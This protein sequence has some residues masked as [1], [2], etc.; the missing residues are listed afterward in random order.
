MTSL[1]I[2]DRPTSRRHGRMRTYAMHAYRMGLLAVIVGLVHAEHRWFTAQK[3][4]Q[5]SESVAID[6]VLPLF[7]N[8]ASLGP[9]NPDHG[10]Q[11]VLNSAG[12]SLGFV[13]QTSP[14]SDDVI[15]FSG[16]I[17]TLVAFGTDN[18]IC[19]MTV[20]RSGDTREHTEDV[21]HNESFMKSLHGLNWQQASAA[22]VDS[23]SGATLT[24]MS[25][26]DG[27]RRRLGG[28]NPSSR[29][30][31]PITI[32]EASAFFSAATGLEPDPQKPS[33]WNVIDPSGAELGKLFRT[34]P[35]ADQMIGY[36]GPTDTLV[37]MDNQ[38]RVLGA[39]IRQSFDNEPYVRYVKEDRYFFNLFKGFTLTDV[40]SLDM[41]DAGIEGVSGATKTSTTVAE[42]LIY[43]AKQIELEQPLTQREPESWLSF[44]GRD[45]GTATV[46]LLSL[47]VALTHLRGK[48]WVRIG[49]QFVLIVYL[50]FI[51][52]DMLSQAQAV[53]WTQNGIAWKAAPALVLLTIAALVC[54]IVTGRQVYCTHLCP[55][56]AMQDWA[57]RV[58]L[59]LRVPRVVDRTLRL[60]PAVL[61][62]VV[63]SVAMLH[64]PLSLVGIEPFDAFV[65]RIAGW[66]TITVA[67]V[68]LVASLFV[69]MAYCHYGC[70]TGA[71]LGY[72]RLTGSSGRWNRR[73]TL[74]TCLTI[75][76]FA[77]YV[78]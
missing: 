66:A 8:A 21:I 17:N 50:G 63:V 78:S 36:Q 2:V 53:G 1:P 70:P 37:A 23:V 25:V 57:R 38:G 47:V 56:G 39:A 30:S 6:K 29:F 40:S 48:R 22:D 72:V 34:S 15:G 71:V 46:V 73:D 24:S 69:P 5:T 14:E 32:Q 10:G 54:P 19:G 7:P 75:F 43:T 49:L 62:I 45:Y 31:D 59:R 64:L 16:P 76:A 28:A 58:P 41:V 74:A 3:R 18:R 26:I 33:M 13:V 20:L 42:A 65:F 60:V 9:F 35:H 44:S 68:G 55:F 27:I 51:N 61:L 11:T 12:E 52:A 77:V 4:G 67:I